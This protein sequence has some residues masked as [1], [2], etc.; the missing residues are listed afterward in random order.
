MRPTERVQGS[1]GAT[2]L[3]RILAVAVLV[4]CAA[5]FTTGCSVLAEL[6]DAGIEVVLENDPRSR[7]H[8]TVT[9]KRVGG[10]STHYQWEAAAEMELRP[11]PSG[12]RGTD[13]FTENKSV[14]LKVQGSG[15]NH[16]VTGSG[17]TMGTFVLRDNGD[18]TCTITFSHGSIPLQESER[19]GSQWVD[20]E[21]VRGNH[22]YTVDVAMSR[23]DGGFAGSEAYTSSDGSEEITLSWNFARK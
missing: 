3:R 22:T 4:A 23:P 13:D 7:L 20:Y 17:K 2:I 9:A 10:V 18:G 14:D 5:A 12:W 19:H 1:P 21:S 16:Q 6:E 11:M 15:E 8:G